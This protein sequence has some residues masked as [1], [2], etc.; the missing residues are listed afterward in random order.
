MQK[1]LGRRGPSLQPGLRMRK[2]IGEIVLDVDAGA[3][4]RTAGATSSAIENLPEPYFRR[5]S[6][7]PA[8]VPGTPAARPVS[9]DFSATAS[10]VSLRKTSRAGIVRRGF[11]VVDGDG[12]LLLGEMDE[13]ETAAAE[14]SRAWQRNRKGKP[15]CDRRIDR[16]A[17]APENIDAD[18]RRGSFLRRH[19]AV[20]A[21]TGKTRAP[22][23]MIGGASAVGWRGTKS[24]ETKRASALATAPACRAQ[25]RG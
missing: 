2:R 4:Q 21:N 3:S 9:R 11:T 23:E 16:I 19:H 20:L 17:A 24:D 6:D 25:R 22:C 15:D 13:H 5:A 14:I 12:L 10:P 18:F 1:N 8:T 7:R